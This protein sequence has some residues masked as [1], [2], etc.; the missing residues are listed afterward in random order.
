MHNDTIMEKPI[1]EKE[2]D[3]YIEKEHPTLML[4]SVDE[5]EYKDVLDN[6]CDSTDS[7]FSELKDYT[8]NKVV[9]LT[10]EMVEGN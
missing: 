8:A 10:K 1:T 4:S 3:E 5:E 6:N 7:V 2:M 9:G